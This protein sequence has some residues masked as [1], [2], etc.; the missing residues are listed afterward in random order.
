MKLRHFALVAAAALGAAA[1]DAPLDV[2]PRQSLPQ[3]EALRTV[4][5]IRA[6]AN[7]MYDALQDCDGAYCR[8]LL[9]FP[10]LYADN[11]RFTGTYSSD[12]EVANRDIRSANTA[13]P[14]IWGEAYRAINRANNILEAVPNVAAL[15]EDEGATLSGEAHFVR[16]LG[17]F[18][19]VKFFGGVPLVTQPVWT[20]SPGVNVARSTEAEIWAFIESEL[21][22]AISQLPRSNAAGRATSWAAKA[23]LARA[24]LYQR[25][26]AQAYARANDVIENGPFA[27]V[28]DYAAVFDNEQ[29]EEAIF[30]VPFS[31][32]DANSLAFWFYTRPLGG[33]WG[34][35]P[36][37]AG[38]NSLAAAFEAEDERRPV[39]VSRQGSRFYGNKYTDVA[40]GTDD[41]PVLR[42]AEMYLIRSE[43]AA[44]MGQLPQAI[45]D[46]NVV[47]ERAG[48]APLDASGMTQ[49]EVLL[50]NLAER[51]RELFYEGHRFFD[52]R[53]FMDI[54][55]VSAYMSALGLTGFRLLFPIPQRELDA[56][57]ALVQNPGY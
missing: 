53:R 50:A 51:R 52:L 30:E 16:A 27:L 33:R 48:V 25:E 37:T 46:I 42:L 8:N 3:E 7:A 22:T 21:T 35:A 5:E 49:E 12:R 18:N 39:A 56:N 31:V 9:V 44:R 38:P 6:G 54:P 34:F 10:D 17:Y 45:A 15:D 40:S 32:T 13:L 14:E 2:N 57:S 47:R 19:L 55:S 11:L 24:H 1:C 28:E 41:V 23:L 26:W 43:A 36:T 29:T 20:V 4:E